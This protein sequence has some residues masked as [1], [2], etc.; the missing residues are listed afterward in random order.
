MNSTHT[1]CSQVFEIHPLKCKILSYLD[2]H[3][4]LQ[5]NLINKEWLDDSYQ[6]SSSYHLNAQ[7]AFDK[8]NRYCIWHSNGKYTTNINNGNVVKRCKMNLLRFKNVAS[9]RTPTVDM[10]I[11]LNKYA[12]DLLQFK[13]LQQLIVTQPHSII[14]DLINSNND[15]LKILSIGDSIGQRELTGNYKY[16]LKIPWIS[17]YPWPTSTNKDE[18]FN[19]CQ[20]I[21]KNVFVGL[22]QLSLLNMILEFGQGIG[23]IDDKFNNLYVL[24]IEKSY[25]SLSFW[26]ELATN[27]SCNLSNL[28][29]LILACNS[30][31]KKNVGHM[32]EYTKQIALKLT[33][34]EKLTFTARQNKNWGMADYHKTRTRGGYCDC[35]LAAGVLLMNLKGLKLRYLN[36]D[37]AT[38]DM[39]NYSYGS[40][41]P[42]AIDHIECNFQNLEHARICIMCKE[43]Y[44]VAKS[45]IE[46][47]LLD[48]LQMIAVS[49]EAK[50]SGNDEIE[51]KNGN[52]ELRTTGTSKRVCMV[53][54]LEFPKPY[55]T[56]C[57]GLVSLWHRLDIMT[58]LRSLNS[59]TFQNLVDLRMKSH[60][61]I[62]VTEKDKIK[63]YSLDVGCVEK[64]DNFC[65]WSHL[66]SEWI[67]SLDLQSIQKVTR[68]LNL[69]NGEIDQRIM[70]SIKEDLYFKVDRCKPK[71]KI[72]PA[73]ETTENST[74][75]DQMASSIL[76]LYKNPKREIELKLLIKDNAANVDF[77]YNFA[78]LLSTKLAANKNV[79]DHDISLMNKD[80]MLLRER[81]LTEDFEY[82][83]CPYE[84]TDSFYK[85]I[86]CFQNSMVMELE[87]C[88]DQW[89][90][91]TICIN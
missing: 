43:P 6:K 9:L 75:L 60:E 90:V 85:R 42:S 49:N 38:K 89:F 27:N 30:I 7:Y 18:T 88:L 31:K 23:S 66:E 1:K 10:L 4:F 57:L 63:H 56:A 19:F 39:I 68:L 25:L 16:Q 82:F 53:T 87:I 80:I 81:K 76:N 21:N 20:N 73:N 55:H 62:N 36:I 69:I 70:D 3:S 40:I 35:A 34:I 59:I 47:A 78:K 33:N 91:F 29:E 71:R 14:L 22:R 32:I 17:T 8:Y 72:Q 83:H 65:S 13:N 86:E 84:K 48:I 37:F 58:I 67:Q 77:G 2:I 51:S 79:N 54:T 52:C 61:N 41:D 50:D 44:T 11:K 74:D 26:Q 12:D 45:A 28:R 24:H 5:C 64:Q 46:E 15:S